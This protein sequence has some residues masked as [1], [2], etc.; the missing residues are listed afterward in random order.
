MSAEP[1]APKLDALRMLLATAQELVR[2]L[3][4]DP[5]VGRLLRAITSLAFTD[6]GR[7]LVANGA[8]GW[9]SVVDVHLETRTPAQISAI[10]E[11]ASSW[12]VVGGGLLPR[13]SK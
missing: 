8:D 13:K 11:S 2:E 9:M 6:D 1:N 3:A 5:L 4:T 12:Q 7:R 10:A